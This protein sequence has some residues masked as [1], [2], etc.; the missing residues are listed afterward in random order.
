MKKG[1]KISLWI[2]GT[3]VVLGTVVFL[4]ADI[5][6]SRVVQ[7]EVSKTIAQLP[8]VKAEVGHIYLNL[9]SGSAVVKDISFSTNSLELADSIDG[10]HA[11]G[12]ALRI[13]KL[14]VW[15][16]SYREL[17]RNHSIAIRKI[18]IDD[19]DVLAFLDEKHPESLLPLLPKD[20]TME[21]ASQWLQAVGVKAV[22]LNDFQAELRSTCSPLFVTVKDLSV[23]GHDIAYNLVD[24]V[25]TYNDSVYELSLGACELHTPDGLFAM[26][27]HDLYTADQGA[28]QLGYTHFYNSISPQ[29]LADK[30][31]EPTTWIDMELNSVETSPFN[32][33]HK[34]MN[35]DYTLESL[36]TSVKRMHVYRDDRYAPK[37]PFMTPQA[38]LRQVP[39][40]FLVKQIE[41]EVEKID[42]Y[43]SSTNVNC[44]EIHA[45]KARAHM[46]NVTNKPGATWYNVAKAPFG[47]EGQ[48]VAKY[49]MIM[50]KAETFE[51]DVH[52]THIEAHDINTFLRPLVGMTCECH[53][54]ALDTHYKG[55][56]IQASGDFCMQYHGLE[57]KVH[58]EDDIPYKI[59][60]KNAG[61]FNSIANTL[62]PK[63][64]PTAVDPAPRK[65]QVSWKND[66]WKA[67]PMYLFGPIIDGVV[68]T[69][70]PGLFVHKQVREKKGV[71]QSDKKTKK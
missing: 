22:E 17:I 45:G 41:A 42:V 20:T 11:P 49:N 40:T 60:T 28:L 61:A 23:A 68:E 36:K 5:I 38:F 66:V 44:G 16:I 1:V 30:M 27:L 15:N 51:L 9:I 3:L 26:E 14:A 39:V 63:S 34:A 56:K 64:N 71:K 37:V 47:K 12:L 25:F 59:V 7:K 21:H 32:P 48:L 52:A 62:I 24:S 58:K 65:Y 35:Q 54:D 53:V 4:C 55:D 18:S 10:Q 43:Y 50:D 57:V 69:M 2:A 46:S 67:Y 13:P 29:K 33:I 8:G 70:L 19:M 31:R 6:V